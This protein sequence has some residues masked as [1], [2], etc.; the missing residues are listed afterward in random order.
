[1]RYFKK[2]RNLGFEDWVII[3]GIFL[4]IILLIT[5]LLVDPPE[6][7]LLESLAK[8]IGKLAG[9]VVEGYEE[10]RK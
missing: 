3:G 5:T 7:G 10:V 6:E 9:E 4:F 1:M 8:G 2:L